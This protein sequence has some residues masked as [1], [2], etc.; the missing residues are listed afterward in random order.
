MLPVP[1]EL[2]TANVRHTE[3]KVLAD[4]CVGARIVPAIRNDANAT[5]TIVI[6]VD[7]FL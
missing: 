4:A 1:L 3:K 2:S 6:P 7:C 5:A